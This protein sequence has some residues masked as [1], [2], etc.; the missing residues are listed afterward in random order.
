MTAEVS[1]SYSHGVAFNDDPTL[2]EVWRAALWRLLGKLPE[3]ER[4]RLA[5]IAIDGTSAT[6]LLVDGGSGEVLAPPRMY[7][8]AQAAQAVA[9][10]KAIAPPDHT[11]TAS[12]STLCKVRE[13]DRRMR[14]MHGS[15]ACRPDQP[16]ADAGRLRT[17][18]RGCAQ[19][20]PAVRP[21]APFRCLRIDCR[22]PLCDRPHRCWRGMMKERG[23]R[24]QQKGGSQLSFTRWEPWR[25][26]PAACSLL[27]CRCNAAPH[28]CAACLRCLTCS[29]TR[30]PPCRR[31]GWLD[32]CIASG[33]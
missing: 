26:A 3:G 20:A 23:R 5:S 19:C 13:R 31:T 9:R 2:D 12:T 22:S 18:V 1:T 21:A 28:P 6:T 15:G 16:L 14:A 11:A 7:N 8:E 4:A 24:R 29:P 32:C 33:E 25:R 10:A 17:A 30:S 27:P